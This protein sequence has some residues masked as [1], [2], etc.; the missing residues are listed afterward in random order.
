MAELKVKITLSQSSNPVAVVAP[1]KFNKYGWVTPQ[2][3]DG[4]PG[5]NIARFNIFNTMTYT[6]GC[7][8]NIH[9]RGDLALNGAF[10]VGLD[11]YDPTYITPEGLRDMIDAGWSP[12]NHTNTHGGAPVRYD[13]I[14]DLEVRMLNATGYKFNDVI[15]PGA[16]N[17]FASASKAYGYRA[18]VSQNGATFDGL[19]GTHKVLLPALT[20]D[21]FFCFVRDF[22]DSWWI[23][24][25]PI[26]YYKSQHAMFATGERNF[27]IFGTHAYLSEPEE[28][29]GYRTIMA[30]VQSVLGDTVLVCPV[31]EIYEYRQMRKMPMTQSLSGNVLTV[32]IN[33]DNL[34]DRTRWRDIS[35]NVSGGTVASVAV[36]GFK[37]SSFNSATG[38][39]NAF[40]EKNNWNEVVIPTDPEIPENTEGLMIP[41][42]HWIIA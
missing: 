34:P 4:S 5:A 24:E 10:S 27:H 37:S 41:F 28:Q 30:N 13:D 36:E 19:A 9:Y 1:Q 12:T 38:L 32:T 21:E 42:G 7:G 17:G 26:D 25:Q 22:D 15:I 33:V 18:I 14:N 40:L 23:G 11:G 20:T 31:R 8:N 3:D 35:L 39:V 6:D 29:A 16:D 2:F